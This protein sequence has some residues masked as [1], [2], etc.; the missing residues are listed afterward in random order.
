MDITTALGLAA[1]ALT[2]VSLIPHVVKTWK[3]KSAK[4]ISLGMFLAFSTDV[5]LWLAYGFLL[6]ELPI[7]VRNAITLLL[8]LAIVAMKLKYRNSEAK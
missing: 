6:Q 1:G 8:A 4:D 3:T 5:A 2:T 7:I